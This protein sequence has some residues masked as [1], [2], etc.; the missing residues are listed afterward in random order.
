MALSTSNS[1]SIDLIQ[2][3]LYTESTPSK[4]VLEDKQK[5]IDQ[6]KQIQEQFKKELQGAGDAA[7]RIHLKKVLRGWTLPWVDVE[8]DESV[9]YDN[10]LDPDGSIVSNNPIIQSIIET[11]DKVRA[12]GVEV[13][14]NIGIGG[15]DLPTQALVSSTINSQHNNLSKEKRGGAPEI[16]FI[17]NDFSPEKV[18]DLLTSLRDRGLLL[19][20][21]FN[22]VSKSGATQETLAAFLITRSVLAEELKKTGVKPILLEDGSEYYKTGQFFVATTGLNEKSVLFQLNQKTYGSEK[23][24][25]E[26]YAML[27]VPDGTG[28][29]F[30][31]F[32][33]VGLL[34]LAVTANSNLGESPKSRIDDVMN[35]IKDVIRDTLELPIE[36]ENNIAFQAA[37]NHVIAEKEKGKSLLIM[38]VYDPLMKQVGDIA[39]Q[40]YSESVQKF[41]Q[42]LDFLSIVG[43]EKMH[44]IWNGAVEGTGAERDLVLFVGTKT[45]EES[46]NPVIPK[47]SGI[48]GKEIVSMEGLNLSTVQ[49][50]S[51]QGVAADATER[52]ILNYTLLLP[53]RNVR[54]VARFIYLFQTIVAVEGKLRGLEKEKAED[55]SYKDYTYLQD[56]VEGYKVQTREI[57]SKMKQ[58]K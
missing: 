40:L 7:G 9:I 19:K 26:F 27:P 20:T 39:Q 5:F 25:D 30:S 48:S 57:L 21:K 11:A 43:S 10:A 15:S 31:A 6:A 49:Q 24:S 34:A 1:Q 58:R 2:D 45:T 36:D 51:L 56:G 3:N 17:G 52:G 35:G 18:I 41:G 29:R 28:G 55:G 33:P 12:D 13:W 14:V 46:R 32:S 53:E 54:Q 42:G 44:S 47:G 50:A 16:Y 8:L 38:I 23:E 4:F 22:V 37:M